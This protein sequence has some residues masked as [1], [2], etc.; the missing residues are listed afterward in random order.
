VARRAFVDDFMNR[1]NTLPGVTRAAINSVLPLGGRYGG[2]A[3]AVEGRALVPGE[4]IIVGSRE[5][6]PEYFG[7][8]AIPLVAGRGFTARDSAE[9]EQVTIIN[10]TMAQQWWPTGDPI[11]QRIRITAGPPAAAGWLRIVGVAGDVRHNGLARPP[12]AEMYRPF[13]QRPQPQFAVVVRTTGDDPAA[14][15]PAVRARLQ[16]IDPNLPM[17]DVRTMEDRVADSFA[18]ARATALLLLV[19]AA[20]ATILAAVAMYGSI[21]YA[22]AQRIPEIGIR[23][24]LGASRLSVY[25]Q[26]IGGAL[27]LSAVGTAV[28]TAVALA[29]APLLRG[30]LFDTRPADPA[31]FA[32]VIVCLMALTA[33]ASVLPARRAMSVDPVIALRSE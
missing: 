6:T 32:A 29:T 3:V 9:A 4:S 28:G 22:V 33:A 8:L 7:A 15:V 17:Y 14:V 16:H 21:W 10:R 18:D 24:A 23:L 27:G 25:R 26:V 30:L 12:A 31:T 19:T 13:A 20:L 2:N 5:I 1:L 11:N